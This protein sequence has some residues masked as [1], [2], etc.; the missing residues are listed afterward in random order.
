M[1]HISAVKFYMGNEKKL[2]NLLIPKSQKVGDKVQKTGPCPYKVLYGTCTF[3]P[4]LPTLVNFVP[5]GTMG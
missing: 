2:S 1:D 3:N 4:N 5:F